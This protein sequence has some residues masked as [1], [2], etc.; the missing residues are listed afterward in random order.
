MLFLT[1]QSESEIGEVA[2]WFDSKLIGVITWV[3][4]RDRAEEIRD[5]IIMNMNIL[6]NG[7]TDSNKPNSNSC[8]TILAGGR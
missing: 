3:I 2:N 7:I 6:V 8:G 5:Q 4:E 1:S